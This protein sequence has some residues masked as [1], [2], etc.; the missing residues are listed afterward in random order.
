MFLKWYFSFGE[1]SNKLL[2]GLL[3]TN[4]Y[5]ASESSW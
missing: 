4:V 3:G 2:N 1:I 5:K